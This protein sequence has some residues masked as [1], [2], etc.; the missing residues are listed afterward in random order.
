[1]FFFGPI[2][3][4]SYL[5]ILYRL[6]TTCPSASPGHALPPVTVG[7]PPLLMSKV[8]STRLV[9]AVGPTRW[10]D[11]KT[12]LSVSAGAAIV[13]VFLADGASSGRG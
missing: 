12:G 2:V 11:V 6:C 3:P 13:E 7:P 4:K 5:L 1:M 10:G 9:V 8:T